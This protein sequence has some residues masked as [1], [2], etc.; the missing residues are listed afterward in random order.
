MRTLYFLLLLVC[1]SVS[2]QNL[3][4]DGKVS[5]KATQSPI[6]YAS[7]A[8]LEN[9]KP[10]SGAMTDD[11]GRFTIGKLQ[12]K[13]YTVEVVFMGFKTWTGTA[14]LTSGKN[15]TLSNVIMEEEATMLKEVN[16]IAER[17]TIEQKIDRK[18]VNVGRDLTT[19]GATA[20]DIMNNI[21]SVNVDQDGKISLRG[22]E[23]VRVLIDGRPST[24]SADQLLKQ[25]PSTSIKKIE[26][27]TNPSAKY[28]PEG[29]SGIIN[30]VLHKNAN[31][32]FNGNVSLGSTIGRTPKFNSSSS[33][34]YRKN[35][36]NLFA[37][38]G[39]NFAKHFNNGNIQRLDD[40]PDQLIDVRNEN[41]SN[42]LKIGADF[43]LND[44]NT[45]SI[46][47]NQNFF[48][49][50]TD[51]TANT[52]SSDPNF[53]STQPSHYINRNHDGTY[54]IAYK[55]T[56]DKEGESLD[57][58]V[59]YSRLKNDNTGRFLTDFVDPSMPDFAYD[60][61]TRARTMQ[62][63]GNVDYVLP[64]G[65]KSKLEVGVEARIM[66]TENDYGTNNAE[67]A[68]LSF[69]Y[70]QNIYSA[71]ATFGSTLGKF[72]YQAGLRF[73]SYDVEAKNF[74]ENVYTDDYLTLY[75]SA[76]LTYS[77]TDK[78]MLQLSYS[79]RVD[80]PG[81]NQVSPNREFSTPTMTSRGNPELDPQFTNSVEMNFIRTLNKGTVTAGVFLRSINDQIS[82]V[83]Y[84]DPQFPDDPNRLLMT[85]ENFDT[86]T[87]IGFE[88]SANYRI[89]KWWD[90]QPA[91]D[92]SSI[93][94]QGIVSIPDTNG[95][96]DFV[97]RTVN[98]SALN[99]RINTNI[100]ANKNLSFLL[101]GFYRSPVDNVQGKSLDMYKVDL[102]ARYSMLNNRLTISMR[103]NDLFNW[104]RYAFEQQYPY[105][106]KG[107]FR[108]ESRTVYFGVNYMFGGGKNRE[109]QRKQRDNNTMQGG[110]GMF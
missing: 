54:N 9:G 25:I 63:T 104:Q 83:I 91:V 41:N 11:N 73:E 34:N 64:I 26:L 89:T 8:V 59:N 47:T 101:F 20:S 106:S 10:V 90:V 46:Y 21:P 105:P 40:G 66:R 3:T 103:S 93:R 15:L 86:N 60:D 51:V 49:G 65:E 44:K 81:F 24:I 92:F 14:D 62:T 71:Y 50:G 108:W 97:N 23:N 39:N 6:P 100:K 45:L 42:L 38:Y 4:L 30:I 36:V 55:K 68:P 69:E 32:G 84:P 1:G 76:S 43:Y 61:S 80:R 28:N 94:Q 67:L 95:D 37:T 31:D 33:F 87:S 98:A 57:A 79:R 17:S 88:V 52:M 56:F 77:F 82:R 12:P 7:V 74:G 27:I 58:E 70:N 102:G 72:G 107:E 75:P 110:G 48:N 99:A 22:N 2:A 109:L 18:V 85:F 5:E 35:A 16:V 96:F 78:N 53:N 13:K 29:M 19:A